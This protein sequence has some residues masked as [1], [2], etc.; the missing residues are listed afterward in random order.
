MKVGCH[1]SVAGGLSLAFQ[2]ARDLEC[3]SFQIFTRNQRQWK[4]KE[5]TAEEIA[6]FKAS[7][8]VYDY[9]DATLCAHASYLIN[10]CATEKEKRTKSLEALVSEMNRCAAL[11]IENVIIH[12]GSHGEKGEAWGIARIADSLNAVLASTKGATK[13]LLETVSGQG[14][15]IGYRFEHLRDIID[16]VDDSDRM[17]ICIDTCHV[18]AAGTGLADAGEVETMFEKVERTLGTARIGAI[19]LNDSKTPY[20]SRRDRHERIGQGMIGP[21]VFEALMCR[22]EVQE[23]PGLLEVPGGEKAFAED[24]TLLRQYRKSS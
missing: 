2:R 1:I 4:V 9:E 20:G 18:H 10:M 15:G 3:E 6:S 7:R 22:A 8:K 21:E 12:P 14:T 19:H 11:E 23:I 5:L 17:G 13:I 16:R 24:M